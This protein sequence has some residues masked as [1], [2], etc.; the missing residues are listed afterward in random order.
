MLPNVFI[1]G[2]GKCGTTSLYHILRQHQDI[3]ISSIKEPSFFC[4]YFQMV[5]DP[6]TYFRLF[7]SDA[8]Y[9]LDTSHVY[10]SNPETAPV[11]KGLFPQAKFIVILRDPKKRAYSLYLHMRRFN[12]HDG[13]PFEDLTDFVAALK[14]E[15]ERYASATFFENCR[16]YFWNF[17]YCRSSLYDQQRHDTSLCTTGNG[18]RS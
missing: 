9:R 18:S 5:K 14:A 12:H 11:L 3:H 10:M 1:L 15:E 16:Q 13:Q 4:S 8:R 6:I 2:A 17:M 7:N